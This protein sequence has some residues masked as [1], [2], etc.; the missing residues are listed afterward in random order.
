MSTRLNFRCRSCCWTCGLAAG[1]T[2]V[3]SPGDPRQKTIYSLHLRQ[4]GHL[5]VFPSEFPAAPVH[6]ARAQTTGHRRS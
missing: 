1:T 2:C 6:P 4:R 3:R 5:T